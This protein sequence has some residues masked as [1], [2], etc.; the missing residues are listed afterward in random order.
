MKWLIVGAEGQLGRA[1]QAE[2]IGAGI[3][4]VALN[5]AQLDITNES[6]I[7]RILEQVHPNVVLNAA[8]WTRVDEAEDAELEARM[9]NSIGP[10]LLAN[11]C[12]FVDSKFVHISTDYVFSGISSTPFGEAE[13]LD[14]QS[15]YGRTKAEG[16]RSVWELYP[17]GS[18]IVRTAWL[19]SPWGRN[20]VKTMV[21]LALSG[22]KVVE[23]VDDQIGQP[24][25]AS[26]LAKQIHELIKGDVAPGTFHGTNSGQASW[27]DFAREIF[28][29]TGVDPDRVIPVNSSDYLRPAKR[30]VFSVLGHDEWGRIGMQPMRDWR[31]ALQEALPSIISSVSME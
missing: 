8:A 29:S 16:E 24:T 5:R 23:V 7:V 27:F 3:E 20:F 21:R 18:F 17:R 11:A 22:S 26:D 13:R 2:L 12:S 10:A 31:E 28:D 14:P 25:S 6:D 9:V 4:L 15:A 19:Y 30:P 1:M